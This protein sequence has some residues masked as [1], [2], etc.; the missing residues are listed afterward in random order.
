MN[1]LVKSNNVGIPL[2]LGTYKLYVLVFLDTQTKTKIQ[3]L[4]NT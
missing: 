4:Y 2:Y 1:G 3:H